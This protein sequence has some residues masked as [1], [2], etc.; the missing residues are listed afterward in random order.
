[1]LLL[2]GLVLF[3][4]SL[5]PI[6]ENAPEP[7]R[8]KRG[9]C[10]VCGCMLGTSQS[11]CIRYKGRWINNR[12]TA[13]NENMETPK[14]NRVRKLLWYLR[15]QESNIKTMPC[16]DQTKRKNPGRSDVGAL[17]PNKCNE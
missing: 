2:V 11:Y 10:I 12:G 17:L 5:L 8:E 14:K 1:M 7:R 4:D 9:S 13:K 3:R 15:C 16:R 6:P